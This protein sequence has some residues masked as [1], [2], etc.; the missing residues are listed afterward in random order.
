MTTGEVIQRIQSL[1]SKGVQSDD[2]RLRP[3]HIY[4]KLLSTTAKLYE[5]QK[6]MYDNKVNSCP[7]RIVNIFQ[8]Q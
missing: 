1:Y 5:Q 6:W 3:R 4:N 8:L 2:S 7:E